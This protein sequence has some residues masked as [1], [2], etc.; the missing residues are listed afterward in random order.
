M[1][2]VAGMTVDPVTRGIGQ[3]R[4]GPRGA[5]ARGSALRRAR[6]APGWRAQAVKRWAVG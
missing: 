3:D 6:R 5:A 2:L 1:V 4:R